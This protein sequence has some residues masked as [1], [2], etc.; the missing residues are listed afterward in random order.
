MAA[1]GE[2]VVMV[3]S[4]EEWRRLDVDGCDGDGFVANLL[5]LS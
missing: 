1:P 3:I 5:E 4:A 2:R